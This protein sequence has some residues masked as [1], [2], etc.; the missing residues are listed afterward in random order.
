[1]TQPKGMRRVTAMISSETREPGGQQEG[2]SMTT[3]FQRRAGPVLSRASS[4]VISAP[5]QVTGWPMQ[6]E[7][8]R[9]IADEP[10]DQQRERGEQPGHQ[11]SPR[12]REQ[13]VEIEM[14]SR[15]AAR[16]SSVASTPAS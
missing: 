14:R 4:Q 15:W 2:S 6:L 13:R 7:Q 10:F 3:P 5:I 12:Q 1:M 9:R 16:P 11:T 8:G